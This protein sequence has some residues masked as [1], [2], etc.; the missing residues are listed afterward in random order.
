MSSDKKGIDLT[1]A[2]AMMVRSINF[3]V[4]AVAYAAEHDDL[5]LF[6]RFA[7]ATCAGVCHID[8]AAY[9][10]QIGLREPSPTAVDGTTFTFAVGVF[11]A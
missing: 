7:L 5:C 10:A 1:C 11:F 3:D 9:F 6:G 2:W 8:G 4:E